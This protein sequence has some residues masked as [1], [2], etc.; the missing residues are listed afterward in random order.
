[1]PS[2]LFRFRLGRSKK[3]GIEVQ[4]LYSNGYNNYWHP[5]IMDF[6]EFVKLIGPHFESSDPIVT[7][8]QA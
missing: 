6:W 2:S 3:I 4:G 1:M 7:G 5:I 8:K